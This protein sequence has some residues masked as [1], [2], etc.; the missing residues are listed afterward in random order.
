[1]LWSSI[2]ILRAA[3]GWIPRQAM[4]VMAVSL[5]VLVAAQDYLYFDAHLVDRG[6]G[7]RR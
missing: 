3:Y 4:I 1:M 2:R 5:M 7:R 6:V